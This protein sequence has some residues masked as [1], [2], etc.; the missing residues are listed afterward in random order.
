MDENVG[1]GNPDHKSKVKPI[2]FQI[3][4]PVH[5]AA[6]CGN[7][8]ILRLLLEKGAALNQSELNMVARRNLRQGADVLT[9]ILKARPSLRITEDTV[10]ASAKNR[11]SNFMLSCILD[12]ENH[13]THSQLVAIAKEY[14]RMGQSHDLIEK[15]I[16]YGERIECD[17]NEML[18]AFIRWSNCGSH[19]GRV[20]DR[21]QPLG[22]MADLILRSILQNHR[23]GR[24]MLQSVLKYYRDV[25]LVFRI[26]PDILDNVRGLSNGFLMLEDIIC[27]SKTVVFGTDTLQSVTQS[28]NHTI[29]L[30]L[31]LINLLLDHDNC[32][33]NKSF[34]KYWI[35]FKI[36]MSTCRAITTEET[37]HLA[38][39]MDET[40]LET[41]RK[42]ARPNVIFPSADEIKNLVEQRRSGTLQ[43]TEPTQAQSEPGTLPQN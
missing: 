36:H 39:Q 32:R 1:D 3:T 22:S 30:N 15:I 8:K 20:L 23:G 6:I 13:L 19:V 26:S 10:R 31:I 25:D 35:P 11:N 12:H 43:Q 41:L 42:N 7:L 21:Y 34:P 38:A 4:R 9:D 29:F 5:A 24:G 14:E 18:I 37:V 27:H 17:R 33:S 16:S 28:S 2:S 40:A